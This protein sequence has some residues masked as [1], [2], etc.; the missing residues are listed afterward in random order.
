MGFIAAAINLN[1][2]FGM[3]MLEPKSVNKLITNSPWAWFG[4]EIKRL[5]PEFKVK[6]NKFYTMRAGEILE[7]DF[8]YGSPN[9]VIRLFAKDGIINESVFKKDSLVFSY[10]DQAI[11]RIIL[12]FDSLSEKA[13][14]D[15]FKII[16]F[17]C[18]AKKEC[19]IK[20]LEKGIGK[21]ID[22]TH[23]NRD[24]PLIF[25]RAVMGMQGVFGRINGKNIPGTYAIDEKF[26]ERTWLP[27]ADWSNGNGSGLFETWKEG[28]HFRE[29][30]K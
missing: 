7:Q 16:M 10:S 11:R 6:K 8:G 20:E 30:K 26:Y 18:R 2:N 12:E 4:T 23:L 17:L 15:W 22:P 25:Y 5:F 3:E 27:I 9:M 1:R 13:Q 28:Y 29:K 14:P 19:T 24:C 21:K